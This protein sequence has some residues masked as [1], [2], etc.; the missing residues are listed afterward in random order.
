MQYEYLCLY[1]NSSTCTCTCRRSTIIRQRWPTW[2]KSSKQPGYCTAT[3]TLLYCRAVPSFLASKFCFA[4]LLVAS[5]LLR[6]FPLFYHIIII[7][8]H[9]RTNCEIIARLKKREQ[10]AVDDLKAQ[11]QQRTSSSSEQSQKLSVR[12]LSSHFLSSLLTEPSTYCIIRF[13]S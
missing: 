3:A 8:C 12:S 1:L 5:R 11:L 4:S 9:S 2:R 13:L 7:L 10:E 6:I